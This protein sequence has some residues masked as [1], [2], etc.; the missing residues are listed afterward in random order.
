[1]K[2]PIIQHHFHPV[3]EQRQICGYWVTL[4]EASYLDSTQPTVSG[5]RTL[6]F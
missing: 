5:D 3:A 4:R 2:F 1:M 6:K